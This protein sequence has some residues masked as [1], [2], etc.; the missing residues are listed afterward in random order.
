MIIDDFAR[1]LRTKW[2]DIFLC[3]SDTV[4]FAQQGR[5]VVTRREFELKHDILGRFE[6][7]AISITEKDAFG[8][9]SAD[10]PLWIDLNA[11]GME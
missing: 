8:D 5:I 4:S 11:V 2:E 1:K 7:D 3:N 6:F 9:A 10:F